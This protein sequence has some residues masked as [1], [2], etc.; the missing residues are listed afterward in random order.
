MQKTFSFLITLCLLLVSNFGFSQSY[1]V[2]LSLTDSLNRPVSDAAI[3]LTD[4]KQKI[5]N[6]SSNNYGKLVIQLEKNS[7]IIE[8]AHPDYKKYKDQIS[9]NKNTALSI[10]LSYDGN[11]L[12]EIVITAKESKGLATS[13]KIDRQAMAHLQPSSFTDLLELLPGGNAKDPNLTGTNVIKLRE[14]GSRNNQYNTSSLGVQ[15]M[16]DGNPMNTNADMQV[17]TNESHSI[18]TGMPSSS[19]NTYNTGI[20]MRTISTNDIDNV[21]IIRGIPTASYGDLTSGLVLINRKTGE[22]AW[23]SRLKIDGFSKL[24]YLAK[25]FKIAKNWSLNTSLD[26]LDAKADPR[27]EHEN[28]Q[29]ISGSLRSTAN[30]KLA[31]NQLKWQTNL[32]YN[33]SLDNETVDPDSGFALIDRYQNKKRYL[34]VVN[35]FDYKISGAFFNRFQLNTSIRKGL[36]DLNQTKLV[37]FSGPRVVSIAT[38]QGVNDGYFPETR[39]ISYLTTEGRPID[40][41]FKLIADALF[42][43]GNLSHNLESGI[44]FRYSKNNGRGQIYDILKPPSPSMT[45]RPRGYNNLPAHQNAAFFIGDRVQYD[46]NTHG[47]LFYVGARV[48]KM[49]GLPKQYAL[50]DKTY[51]EPRANFQWN[52]PIL[53]INNKDLKTDVTLGYGSL[54]KQPTLLMLYPNLR[55]LDFQQLNFYHNN[56]DLRYVN[57]M[58]YV[59]NPT[60]YDLLAAKNVKKEIRLDFSYEK[61]NFFI[62]YFNEDMK[63]GFRNDVQFTTY[64]YNRYDATGLDLENMTEKPNIND[65]P[66]EQRYEFLGNSTQQN[67]SRTLKKGIEFGYSSP[68]FKNLNTRI[69]LNGAWFKTLYENTT[70]LHEKPN[71]SVGGISFPYVGIYKNDYGYINTG[72]RY[73]CIIDTYLKDLDMNISVS[74]QG[75]LFLNEERTK[76]MAEP[77]AYYDKDGNIFEFQETDRTDT[78]KQWLI[79]NVTTTDNLATEYTFDM[80]ANLKVTKRIYDNVNASLFVNR[81]FSYYA[82]Y[83]FNNRTIERNLWNEPYFGMELTFNF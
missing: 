47:F 17:S 37:Q 45:T 59:V 40:M 26:Y 22:T 54:Y 44:D 51:I 58:T 62:T 81:L 36:E 20:D 61:H 30:L 63:S 16:M 75:T 64:Y 67:G 14:F 83:T 35:N 15:F 46:F 3:K 21:E 13:S 60:N 68:R 31:N 1:S 27:N 74:L 33:L 71:Q 4:S 42:F 55:F 66:Y 10:K 18:N 11:Q 77:Y 7:Y 5:F 72:L 79:R 50:A 25:G 69:T 57:F 41:S 29:R 6:F 78:Y 82:P 9:I 43:T 73:N 53:K 52:A 48:S 70:P 56:P 80:V 8:I 28:Y 34:S 19:R 39:Y 2:Q 38:E 24:Y 32:D 49:I 65:L 76:R 23:Q 12:E